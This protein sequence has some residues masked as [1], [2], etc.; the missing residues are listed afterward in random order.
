MIKIIIIKINIVKSYTIKVYII[1]K[2]CN[3]IRIKS[4]KTIYSLEK[5]ALRFSIIL[6]VRNQSGTNLNAFILFFNALISIGTIFEY[7]QN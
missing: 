7:K 3:K 5:T 2:V 1:A 4:L 6:L